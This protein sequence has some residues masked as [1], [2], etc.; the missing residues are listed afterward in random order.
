MVIVFEDNL[1]ISLGKR[2]TSVIVGVI[3]D[4]SPLHGL[5]GAI[6]AQV[7]VDDAVIVR[8]VAFI[9]LVIADGGCKFVLA[10]GELQVHTAK[11]IL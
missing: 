8:D 1:Y 2:L 4:G 6:N 11:D 3:G 7:G 5:S 9:H 10:F